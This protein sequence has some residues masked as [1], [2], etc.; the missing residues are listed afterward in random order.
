MGKGKLVFTF[1]YLSPEVL[2]EQYPQIAFIIY[3]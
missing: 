3:T 2:G 1:S